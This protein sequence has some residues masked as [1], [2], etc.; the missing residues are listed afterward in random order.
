MEETGAVQ[1]EG[2]IREWGN[3]QIEGEEDQVELIGLY[4]MAGVDLRRLE[5]TRKD[6][7]KSILLWFFEI[8]IRSIS[9]LIPPSLPL[10]HDHEQLLAPPQHPYSLGAS[11]P[12]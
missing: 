10:K 5:V 7:M 8:I 1:G 9:C 4:H 12:Y 11:S 6:E 2:Y 3:N